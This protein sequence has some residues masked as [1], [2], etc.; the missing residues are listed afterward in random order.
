M[1]DHN[2]SSGGDDVRASLALRH[3]QQAAIDGC[4]RRFREGHPAALVVLPTGTGK[5]YTALRMVAATISKGGRVLWIAHRT[6][7][8]TQPVTTWEGVPGLAT[9]RAGIVQGSRNDY[10][11]DLVCASAQTIGRAPLKP[12]SKL[13]SILEAQPPVRVIVVDEC[14][15][16]ADDGD[17]QFAELLAAISTLST[18]AGIEPRFVG[19]TATPERADGRAIAGFWGSEPASVY[20]YQEAIAEGYLVEP[21]EVLDR[22]PLDEETEQAIARARKAGDGE[23]DLEAVARELIRAG[24]SEHAADCM[25]RHRDRRWL[26]FCADV[27]QCKDQDAVLTA[28]GFRSAVVTGS[29][30]AAQRAALLR[31]F[32]AG[33]IDALVNC[34]VLTEGTDLPICDGVVAARP[35]ASK[36]LWIQSVGRGLR[37]NESTNKRDCIVLDLVGATEEHSLI[38]AAALLEGGR[39]GGEQ[40]RRQFR[41]LLV[42]R[43]R[44]QDEEVLHPPLSVDVHPTD[45]GGWVI[46]GYH[47]GED[48]AG[49]RVGVHPPIPVQVPEQ[50]RRDG[51]S[52]VRLPNHWKDRARVRA[53]FVRIAERAWV[54]GLGKL[55]RAYLVR[56]T[57]DGWMLFYLPKK[58]RKPRPMGQ[59]PTTEGFARGL[60]DDLYRQSGGVVSADARW[61]DDPPTDGQQQQLERLGV[62]VPRTKGE[63]S[64]MLTMA[65]ALPWWRNG[66]LE[67]C[68]AALGL[69]GDETDGGEE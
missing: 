51:D 68:R 46:T 32:K 42:R 69:A 37:L 29:T 50:V 26:V 23:G 20:T 67:K 60:G 58:A 61:R 9:G 48:G 13:R 10:D 57:D 40:E 28:R 30:P 54:V 62:R 6:E 33:K 3:Y 36:P 66:G 38:H 56:V 43:V 8:V 14:H 17:G 45:D 39:D 15:H 5:T 11:A 47:V 64:D 55:G 59:R 25:D 53:N 4:R 24:I 16:Y 12:G 19:L 41:G 52:S 49:G 65:Y 63:A 1:T 22:V 27:A 2:R 35:F 44:G 31:R 34:N 18:E 21:I 7:L